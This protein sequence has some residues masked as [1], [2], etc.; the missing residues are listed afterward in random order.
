MYLSYYLKNKIRLIKIVVVVVVFL[1]FVYK[2]RSVIR[3]NFAI[4][5]K[6]G[7]ISSVHIITG[8]GFHFIFI[9]K[10][11]YYFRSTNVVSLVPFFFLSLHPLH[12]V[13]RSLQW[14]PT[15]KRHPQRSIKNR[16]F[17]SP[18]C[19]VDV[20]R[21]WSIAIHINTQKHMHVRIYI[22]M[23]IYTLL[24]RF[25]LRNFL[26]FQKLF[27]VVRDVGTVRPDGGKTDGWWWGSKS[28]LG[29]CGRRSNGKG[30]AGK[31]A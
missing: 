5:S 2:I 25:L 23:Y 26:F 22:Y 24:F 19:D 3:L 14:N 28:W 31:C 9:L 10:I 7:S 18:R 6:V 12:S 1:H 21:R 16:P 11:K 17:G 8:P 15:G 4:V 27:P 30:L 20:R 29:R 13:I